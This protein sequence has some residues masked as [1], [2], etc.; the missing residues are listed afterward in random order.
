MPFTLL[1]LEG[2]T[3]TVHIPLL[4]IVASIQPRLLHRSTLPHHS[5]TRRR[6]QSTGAL[7]ISSQLPSE[8]SVHSLTMVD[9]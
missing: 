1:P 6:V 7:Y 5:G 2:A 8:T 3:V 4:M 9:N